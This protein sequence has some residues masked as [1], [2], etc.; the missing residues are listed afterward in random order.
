[1]DF[2]I[3][4]LNVLKKRRRVS[5]GFKPAKKKRL[6]FKLSV[7]LKELGVSFMEYKRSKS[8]KLYRVFV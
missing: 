6:S 2:D 8:D 1:M 7:P 3:E 4:L 5:D